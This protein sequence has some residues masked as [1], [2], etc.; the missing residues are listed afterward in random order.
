MPTYVLQGRYSTPGV[1][2]LVTKPQNR[3]VAVRNL[4]EAAGGRMLHFYFT[5]GDSDF[6]V[7]LHSPDTE[8]AVTTSMVA[9]AS[10][11]VTDITT[12]QAWSA[13]EFSALAERAG[14]VVDAYQTPMQS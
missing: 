13:P 4:I 9:A 1:K 2:G 7:I 10:G 5:T 6:L 3:E 11:A 14:N 8:T 12:V